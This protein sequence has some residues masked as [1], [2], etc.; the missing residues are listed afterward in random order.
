[1]DNEIKGQSPDPV[2]VPS[3]TKN[4][5]VS[6]DIRISQ[7]M[8]LPGVIKPRH[9]VPAPQTAGSLYYSDGTSFKLL[10]PGTT[11]Q[12]VAI[13]NGVPTY[14]TLAANNTNG[15]NSIPTT[16]TFSSS[17]APTYIVS[18]GISLIG[19]VQLG[20]RIWVTNQAAS[21]YFIVTAIS[22][23]T[24]TL[25]GGTTY[26]LTNTAITAPFFSHQKDPLGFNASS[27]FWKERLVDTTDR[28]QGTPVSGTWY[29]LGSLSLTLPIGSW[30]VWYSVCLQANATSAG[31]FTTLS[32]A[33]NTES[34]TDLTANTQA[35]GA[36]GGGQVSK[37]KTITV[38]SKTPYYINTQTQSVGVT[39]IYN[40]NASTTGASLVIE[41]VC[42]Y[43]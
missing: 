2:S 17:D 37:Q 31:I 13:T 23:G 18:T 5:D 42:A 32:T 6:L 36:F 41:A 26:S 34:D 9:L 28:S 22:A 35:T 40:R 25:Y 27:S 3:Q 20:D 24:L 1:M 14:Q 29:N 11:N 7:D 38:A 33:N 10:P 43:L 16:L 8:I 12:V 39:T 21:Q 4:N 15:W 30:N 19:T